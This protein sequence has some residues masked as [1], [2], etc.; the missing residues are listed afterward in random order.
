[1]R[2]LVKLGVGFDC[3]SRE[4][5]DFVS[6]TVAVVER[7]LDLSVTNITASKLLYVLLW[8]ALPYI[9]RVTVK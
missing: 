3:A 6:I 5:I 8:F 1:M 2:M 7:P 9:D 4:E